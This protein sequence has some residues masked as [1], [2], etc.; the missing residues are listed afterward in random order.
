MKLKFGPLDDATQ[1]RVDD[2]DSETLLRWAGNVL[3]AESLSDV[4]ADD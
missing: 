2:A 4:F 3:T 1:K